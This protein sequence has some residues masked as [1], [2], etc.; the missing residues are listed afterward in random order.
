[1]TLGEL[2]DNIN[3]LI[4]RGKSADMPVLITTSDP[5]MGGRASVAVRNIVPGMDWEKREIRLEPAEQ[6]LT[7]SQVEQKRNTAPE[8]IVS[9]GKKSMYQCEV[10]KAKITKSQVY[11]PM[12]GRKIMWFTEPHYTG[13]GAIK[14]PENHSHINATIHVPV[15]NR[16]E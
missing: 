2:Q 1:M 6:L 15:I 3:E 14:M 8:S 7:K 9:N 13:L 16:G 10:C 5:S 12:C 11:C 4:R